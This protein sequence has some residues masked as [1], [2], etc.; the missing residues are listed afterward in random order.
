MA[1]KNGRVKRPAIVF[2]IKK[3]EPAGAD[4]VSFWKCLLLNDILL[5]SLEEISAVVA[6]DIQGQLLGEVEAEDTHD[7]LCV[8]SVSAGYDV[9]VILAAGYEG[10][11]ILNVIDGVDVDLYCSHKKY[12]LSVL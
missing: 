12:F 6:M 3:T 4:S 9:Y 11:E 10:N 5:D 8:D 1:G 7:G 2:P